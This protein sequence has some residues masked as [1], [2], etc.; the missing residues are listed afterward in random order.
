MR[1]SYSSKRYGCLVLSSETRE[2]DDWLCKWK[3]LSIHSNRSSRF[4]AAKKKN[5]KFWTSWNSAGASSIFLC[6][7]SCSF[8]PIDSDRK[9]MSVIVRTPKNE[10]KLYCKGAVSLMPTETICE[11]SLNS[12]AGQ[13]HYGAAWNR[14]SKCAGHLDPS[15]KFC[16]RWSANIMPRLSSVIHRG[17]WG[18]SRME[19]LSHEW[20]RLLNLDRHGKWN[21]VRHQPGSTIATS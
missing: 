18:Q 1:S 15:R 7:C 17:V 11:L 19:E 8:S 20:S 13:C 4:S 14:E 10:I 5:T 12:P 3:L 6:Y 9:R 16:E 21:T 2:C